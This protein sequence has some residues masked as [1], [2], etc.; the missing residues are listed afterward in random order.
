MNSLFTQRVFLDSFPLIRR[1]C[2]Y[3]RPSVLYP[4]I[5]EKS[6]NKSPG[7]NISISE[8]LGREIA[9]DTVVLTS[10]NRYER[11]K[12]IPLALEAFAYYLKNGSVNTLNNEQSDSILVIA[13]GYDD[14]L[15]ENVEIYREL[16]TKARELGIDNRIVFLRS[17][18]NDQRILLL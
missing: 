13:G 8:L 6:F 17:I 16:E 9:K 18:T 11:K 3:H 15:R 10:L 14:R 1:F 2:R 5:D 4:S 7:F 12:N